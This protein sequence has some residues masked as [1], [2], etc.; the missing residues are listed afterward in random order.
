M[1]IFFTALILLGLSAQSVFAQCGIQPRPCCPVAPSCPVTTP[2]P[3]GAAATI[4]PNGQ[5]IPLTGWSITG[6]A[7]PVWTLNQPCCPQKAPT[8]QTCP[9][10]PTCPAPQPVCPAQPCPCQPRS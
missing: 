10:Q 2:A 8:V 1:K 9:C 6:G 4:I 5:V 3:T 7:S